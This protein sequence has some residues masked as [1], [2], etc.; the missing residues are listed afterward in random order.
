MPQNI[1]LVGERRV[2]RFEERMVERNVDGK[3]SGEAGRCTESLLRCDWLAENVI[4]IFD[5]GEIDLNG[6]RNTDDK[7]RSHT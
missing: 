2:R 5:H 1:Y 6:I 4:V 7:A 3:G